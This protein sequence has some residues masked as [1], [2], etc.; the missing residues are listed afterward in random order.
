MN[1]WSKLSPV[2]KRQERFKKWLAAEGVKFNSRK[3]EEKYKRRV[4]RFIDAIMLRKP[5]KTP[6]FAMMGH[7]PAMYSG[8]T[9]QSVM[10]DYSKLRKAWMKFLTEF[11]L[12]KFD[13]FDAGGV[14]PGRVL[15]I[16]DS[17]IYKWPGHG[18]PANSSLQY[19]E[20][21]YMKAEDYDY[22]LEDPSDYNLKV[23]LPRV[24]GVFSSLHKLPSFSH[25]GGGFIGAFASYGD[26]EVKAALNRI[27]KAGEEL[28]RWR[29]VMISL[30]RKIQGAGY[31]SFYAPVAGIPPEAPLDAL[32]NHRR[33]TVGILTD[34]YRSTDKLLEATERMTRMIIR[35]VSYM[36]GPGASPILFMGI[37][38][39]ADGFIS[40][41]Q[42]ARFYW[43]FLRRVVLS[44]ADE[45]FVPCIFAEGGY[46]S[47]LDI[48]KDLPPNTVI[49]HF[50]LT[51]MAAAKKVLGGSQCIMGNVPASLLITGTPPDIREY[52]KKLLQT[53]G[54][55]G[56]FILAPGAGTNEAK[57]EN[58]S[59]MVDAAREYS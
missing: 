51:D 58:I 56:G 11:D 4:Q 49:W 28:H 24:M 18:V 6:V 54:R 48:V 19:T 41:K 37:H 23:Y 43:P 52:C 53:V 55:D 39:G 45:G 21:E 14:F 26:P 57:L 27:I 33:G 35:Q 20:C 13:T 7:M 44:L 42:Y 36:A 1:E 17:K 47:R 38:R 15:D 50:D 46:N 29:K 25:L 10:Y 30:G 22:F 12:S 5:D 31:P 2:Q 16:L 59:A 32:A 3:A 8:E 40:D 34:L 9:H